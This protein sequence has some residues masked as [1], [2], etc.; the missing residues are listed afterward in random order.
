MKLR[1][2]PAHT[3]GWLRRGDLEAGRPPL[4][5][6]WEMPDGTLRHTG[7]EKPIVTTWR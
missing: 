5:Y 2:G 4:Y 1:E 6:V 7:D 3:F